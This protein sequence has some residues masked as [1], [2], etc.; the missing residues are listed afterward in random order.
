M[1]RLLRPFPM[2]LCGLALG[3]FSRLMDICT[4][5]LGDVFS[6]MP[7]WILLGVLIAIG[8]PSPRRAATNILPFCLGMLLAYYAVAVITDGVYGRVYIIGWTVFALCSPLFAAVTWLCRGKG[9]L[10]LLLRLGVAVCAVFSTLLLSGDLRTHDFLLL[11]A[12]VWLLFA[13]PRLPT[14]SA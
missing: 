4:D 14:P 8:S 9:V 3:I 6:R 1:S 10:P 2:L 7:V 5:F 11:A 13:A 12:V